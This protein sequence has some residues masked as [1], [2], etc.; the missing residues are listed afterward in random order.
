MSGARD[1]V[2][3]RRPEIKRQPTMISTYRPMLRVTVTWCL[4]GRN[5]E[6][7]D[8]A[9]WNSKSHNFRRHLLLFFFIHPSVLF[10]ALFENCIACKSGFIFFG[11]RIFFDQGKTAE[12]NLWRRSQRTRPTRK[13]ESTRQNPK[14]A[15][16]NHINQLL[17]WQYSN[18]SLFRCLLLVLIHHNIYLY[19]FYIHWFNIISVNF[20]AQNY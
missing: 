1:F 9:P 18:G 19:W 13:S 20:C 14:N 5:S 17:P 10:S 16:N 2:F 12:R 3:T 11:S 6:N 8:R 15:K 7:T 4:V